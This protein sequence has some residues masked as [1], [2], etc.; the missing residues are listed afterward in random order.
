ME[1]HWLDWQNFDLTWFNAVQ[2]DNGSEPFLFNVGKIFMQLFNYI[3]PHPV[4]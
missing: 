1:V 3:I 4:P 2:Y